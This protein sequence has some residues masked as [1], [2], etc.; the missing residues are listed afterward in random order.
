MFIYDFGFSGME[1]SDKDYF[2]IEI[3]QDYS[4]NFILILE[5]KSVYTRVQQNRTFLPQLYSIYR[6]RLTGTRV[7]TDLLLFLVRCSIVFYLLQYL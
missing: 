6:V 7:H 4:T 3:C 5:V 2:R 1:F